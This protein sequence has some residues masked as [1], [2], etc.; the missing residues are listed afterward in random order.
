MHY[1][2][3]E[4]LGPFSYSWSAWVG[5]SALNHFRLL[6]SK[7]CAGGWEDRISLGNSFRPSVQAAGWAYDR[8]TR[9]PPQ[10]LVFVDRTYRI[11]G[12]SRPTRLRPDIVKAYPEIDPNETIG[13]VAYLPV[14]EATDVTV[15]MVSRD[16][17]EMCFIADARLPGTYV[18]APASK[19]GDAIAGTASTSY[20]AWVSSLPD[21]VVPPP[22]G[23]TVS[24][25]DALTTDSSS[26]RVGPITVR[27]GSTI[28]LPIVTGPWATGV[29]LSAIDRATN[30][31]IATAKAPPGQM[32]WDLWRIDIPRGVAT[33]SFDYVVE[34]HRRGP[35]DW[36]VVGEPRYVHAGS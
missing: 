6:S 5:D 9:Q 34:R 30:E 28:G 13:W 24:S 27:G 23:G 2:R 21:G 31:T 16:D 29:H 15:F 3:R 14:S 33:Q 7:S 17:R 12:F 25:S 4:H 32:Q 18:T 19:A 22:F 1:L 10:L 26:L 35:G 36:V 20:D 8:R 11:L